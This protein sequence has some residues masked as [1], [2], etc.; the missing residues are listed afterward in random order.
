MAKISDAISVSEQFVYAAAFLSPVLYI[1]YERYASLESED[2]FG[3][4]MAETARSVF[5]G[6]WLVSISAIVVLLLTVSAYS[7][8]KI[9]T[10]DFQ[11]TFLYRFATDSAPWLYLYALFC[12]Y[13][14][15]LDGFGGG[16]DFIATNRDNEEELATN[17]SNRIQRR[18]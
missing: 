11:A 10:V 6:Y 14:S 2:H 9:N 4:K 13:L 12:W 17:F 3:I 18:D 8:N 5:K 1:I 16:G 15:I 7:A